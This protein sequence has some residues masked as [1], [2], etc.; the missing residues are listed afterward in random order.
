[1]LLPRMYRHAGSHTDR[2]H[3]YQKERWMIAMAKLPKS[4]A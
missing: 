1:M 2:P 4:A 3:L